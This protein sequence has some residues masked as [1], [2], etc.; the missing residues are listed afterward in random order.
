MKRRTTVCQGAMTRR[1]VAAAAA[2]GR[3]VPA[4]AVVALLNVAMKR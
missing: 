1:R 2:K 3:A 4:V